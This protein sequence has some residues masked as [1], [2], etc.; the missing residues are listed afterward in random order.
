VWED[1][2]AVVGH[3]IFLTYVV[4]NE[5]IVVPENIDAIR[6]LTSCVL[7]GATSIAATDASLGL[8]TTLP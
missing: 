5:S 1:T 4:H 8:R 7:D 2:L 3:E 6:A